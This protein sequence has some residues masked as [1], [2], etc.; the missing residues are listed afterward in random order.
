ML[1]RTVWVALSCL[2][3]LALVLGSCRAPAEEE[4]EGTTVT[5]KVTEKEAPAVEEEEE[6]VVV[7][8]G[9]EEPQYGGTLIVMHVHAGLEPA[10]WDPAE[11]NWIVEPFTSPFMEKLATGDIEGKGPRGSNE[12][13][14]TDMEFIPPDVLRGGL[15]E[16]WE[17]LDDT[18]VIYNIRKGVYWQ[19]RPG[20]MSAREFT[21]E[22]VAYAKTRLIESARCPGYYD[23]I[24]SVTALDKYTVQVKLVQYDANWMLP[25]SWGYFQRI[26][27]KEAVDAGITDWRNA[28]GTGPFVLKDYVGGS[29]LTFEKNPN[30]WGTTTVNGKE[31][32]I[33]FV[34]RLV[35]PIM[36][37]A[38]TQLA[39]LRTGKIDIEESVGWADAEIIRQEMPE[40]ASYRYVGTT[41][42]VIAT[43][44]DVEPFDNQNIRWALNMAIDREGMIESLYGGNAEM[45]GFP[46]SKPWGEDYY[47]PLEELSEN[48]QAMFTYDPTRAKQLMAEAGYPDGFMAKVVCTSGWADTVSLLADYW[49]AINVE[50]ELQVVEYGVYYAIMR[51][52]TH[53]QMYA[54]SKGCG[55]P[56]AVLQVIG[57]PGQ[58]WNPSMFDDPYFTETYE[59]A[60]AESDAVKA[61]QMLKSLNAYIIEKAPYVILPVGYAY[62]FSFPWVKN[63]YGEVSATTRSPGEIHARIWVDTALKREMGY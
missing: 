22:D 7:A 14:F 4:K 18:T 59:A 38:S 44:Y 37:D 13:A 46:F 8:P 48:A 36:P 23:N 51:G 55:D 35:W 63:W 20:V 56:F 16:S 26:Y 27:P 58:Y 33:P 45:L 34:D 40:L 54:M 32:K 3:V 57:N 24:E 29:T 41:G 11:C 15:A 49:S 25:L 62:A 2:I 47:T 53:E 60:E 31:Y 19:D 39:A 50:L 5:G 28:V 61:K 17:L 21:A 43:R 6:A 1:K 12:F 9:P 42:S 52:K 30:Y 10:S